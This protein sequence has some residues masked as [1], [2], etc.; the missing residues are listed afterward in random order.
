MA[1]LIE[2]T[3]ITST[4]LWPWPVPSLPSLQLTSSKLDDPCWPHQHCV[5]PR[6]L[7]KAG[8]PMEPW[9]L[10]TGPKKTPHPL[11]CQEH[12]KCGVSA[13]AIL[14]V[15]PNS[16]SPHPSYSPDKGAAEPPTLPATMSAHVGWQQWQ[17]GVPDGEAC[18][19]M[20]L[21]L[22]VWA[23][24]QV[25]TSTQLIHHAPQTDTN[26][27]DT[28]L[29]LLPLPH[30]NPLQPFLSFPLSMRAKARRKKK[31]RVQALPRSW[32]PWESQK[33]APGGFLTHVS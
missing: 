33:K 3:I 23:M 1:R 25:I 19:R 20:G 32:R 14:T 30:S 6:D 16:P 26:K 12:C 9:G 31:T 28:F 11:G 29:P 18:C 8:R 22:S 17:R 10:T 27:E 7:I 4:P 2:R 5:T 24:S 13:P 21:L 15:M